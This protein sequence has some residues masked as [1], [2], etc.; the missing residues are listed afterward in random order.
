[1]VDRRF[2]RILAILKEIVE[3]VRTHGV[4]VSSARSVVA[5]EVR[6]FCYCTGRGCSNPYRAPAVKG[7]AWTVVVGLEI[8][9]Q[10]LQSGIDPTQD[11]QKKRKGGDLQG[12]S[13]TDS[14]I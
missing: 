5:P 8:D 11:G 7:E 12:D 6:V 3:A 14:A 13:L 2:F 10:S 9:Q 1:M 4:A